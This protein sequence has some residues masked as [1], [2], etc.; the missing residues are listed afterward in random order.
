MGG[1]LIRNG[2]AGN[3]GP[4]SPLT[5]GVPEP[6]APRSINPIAMSESWQALVDRLFRER[7]PALTRYARANTRRLEDAEDIIQAAY[8][9]MREVPDSAA[10]RNPEGYLY[11][12]VR[13]LLAAKSE[14]LRRERAAVA[15]DDPVV[16]VQFA[17]MPDFEGA[18]DAERRV[19][20]VKQRLQ[21]LSAKCQAAVRMCWFDGMSYE[22]AAS[23]LGVSVNMVKKHL[24]KAVAHCRCRDPVPG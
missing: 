6:R 16:E 11:T 18:I 22:E 12:I 8:Q 10:I 1:Y 5:K 15:I 19:A 17:D 13:N 2:L 21:E 3:A 14:E 23:R 24:K 4:Y 9:R 7:G 20:Q